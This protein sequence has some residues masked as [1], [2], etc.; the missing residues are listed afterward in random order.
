[1][2]VEGVVW[3]GGLCGVAGAFVLGALGLGPVGAKPDASALESFTANGR[4]AAWFSVMLALGFIGGAWASGIGGAVVEAILGVKTRILTGAGAAFG[5]GLALRVLVVRFALPA[6]SDLLRRFRVTQEVDAR[7]DI[8]DEHARYIPANFDPVRYFEP[9]QGVFVGLS[10]AKRPLYIEWGLFRETHGQVI[11]PTR[12]GKGVVLGCVMHQVIDAG[13]GCWYIDPKGDIH[14]PNILAEQAKAKGVPF[15]VVD[16][17]S[18]V[19]GY[20]PFAGGTAEERAGRVIAAYKLEDAG[21]EGDY[22]RRTERDIVRRACADIA[23]KDASIERLLARV[24]HHKQARFGDDPRRASEPLSVESGL[25]EWM[26]V[27]AVTRHPS[28]SL[29]VARA[30]RERAVVYIR[31]RTSGVT[32]DI[33]RCLLGELT[34]TA[35]RDMPAA[36]K[37]HVFLAVDE[38]RSMVSAPLVAA[39]TT[40]AGAGVTMWLAYQSVLDMRNLDDRRLDG[41]SVEGAINV[42]CQVKILYGTN[43]VET[44]EWISASSGT[45]RVQLSHTEQTEV[46]PWGG[47]RWGDKRSVKDDEAALISSNT[48]LAL[49]ARIAV[50]LLPTRPAELMWTGWIRY[51]GG[52]WDAA[53][54]AAKAAA[55]DPEHEGEGRPKGRE[56]PAPAPLAVQGL[57]LKK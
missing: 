20:S 39:L 30:L 46:G 13:M 2:T 19:G 31:C 36:R 37:E 50:A 27:A 57:P 26:Q 4:R 56:L 14:A 11:A 44:A 21:S 29:D 32:R 12:F 1:M 41:G 10:S 51:A 53:I 48:V 22:Y 40:V 18:N 25:Q 15:V 35:L 3:T 23:P 24:L 5:G 16:L 7:V 34:D 45:K 6:A 49:P 47:E 54:E 9:T 52:V 8:R 55:M 43:D 17:V 42:N 33:A 38:A 28:R